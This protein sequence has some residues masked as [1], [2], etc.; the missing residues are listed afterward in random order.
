MYRS[1]LPERLGDI[2]RVL[3]GWM[4]RTCMTMK[5]AAVKEVPRATGITAKT[6][7]YYIDF[8]VSTVLVNTPYAKF[9]EGFPQITRRHFVPFTYPAMERWARRK[10]FDTSKGGGLWTWGYNIPFM[11]KAL[12]QTTPI[13]RADAQRLRI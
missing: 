8:P 7:Q 6:V 12:D 3:T 1:Y 13:A 2:R 9:I 5:G 4:T 11:Q 10:G